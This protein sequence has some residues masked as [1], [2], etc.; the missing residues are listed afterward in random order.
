MKSL[1]PSMLFLSLAAFA[2]AAGCDN[3]FF[4]AKAGSSKTFTFKSKSD[5]STGSYTIRVVNA[6]ASG[7]TL[8]YEYT[9]PVQVLESPYTCT[10]E[11]LT[12]PSWFSSGFG[13]DAKVT[14]QVTKSSGIV[15]PAASRWQVGSS[16]TYANEGTMT[17]LDKT[18]GQLIYTFKNEIT[19]R[20]VGQEQVKVPA[21]SFQAF[22]VVLTQTGEIGAGGRTQPIAYTL[23]QWYAK[24]VGLVRQEDQAGV[25][26][27]AS[28]KP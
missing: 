18:R 16:W 2:L 12:S 15:I 4:P 24:E 8:R 6:T 25:H 23:I 7:F 11:G 13:P 26:E 28:F 20:I 22:K 21:G 9:N 17:A 10:P 27:L 3:P 14:T 1:V 19:F 5:G